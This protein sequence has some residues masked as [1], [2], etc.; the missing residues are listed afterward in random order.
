MIWFIL[1]LSFLKNKKVK[2]IKTTSVI[3][4]CNTFSSTKE[5]GPPFSLKP[6]LLAGT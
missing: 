2:T 3:T 6:I 4:S 5:K 1:M